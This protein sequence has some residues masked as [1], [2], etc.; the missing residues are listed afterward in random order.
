VTP[1]PPS[2]CC[3]GP[4]TNGG[5]GRPWAG[6][7]AAPS[8][9]P[10]PPP[11]GQDGLWILRGDPGGFHLTT[12]SSLAA[13]ALTRNHPAPPPVHPTRPASL[14]RPG[15]GAFG[16]ANPADPRPERSMDSAT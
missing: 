16:R 1:P 4:S 7:A 6:R 13:K 2:R 14:G 9:G 5:L 10:I 11:R 8:A 3:T 12:G 15:G